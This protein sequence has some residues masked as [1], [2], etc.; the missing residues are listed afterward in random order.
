MPVHCNGIYFKITKINSH[1][2][3]K[4]L[5]KRKINEKN[6]YLTIF[7]Y[8]KIKL[9]LNT[10]K[11]GSLVSQSGCLQSLCGIQNQREERGALCLS[12]D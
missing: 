7:I 11:N 9:D 4:F 3:D 10:I 8:I 6:I 2:N 1:T 12:M 5:L